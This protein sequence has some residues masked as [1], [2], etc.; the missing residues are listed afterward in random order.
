MPQLKRQ[1][2]RPVAAA[3]SA[4]VT[5]DASSDAKPAPL[6]LGG[7]LAA[8]VFAGGIGFGVD[9][10]GTLTLINFGLDRPIARALA[11]AAALLATYPINR[12]ITFRSEASRTRRGMVREGANYAVVG[13]ATGILNWAVFTLAIAVVPALNTIVAVVFSSLVAMVASYIGYSKFAFRG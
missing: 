12:G 7:R 3:A 13:I 9:L 11:M 1:T 2:K 10:L 5:P 4:A 6:A 8:F